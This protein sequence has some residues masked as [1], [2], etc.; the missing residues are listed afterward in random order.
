MV[1][2]EQVVAFRT[3]AAGHIVAIGRMKTVGTTAGTEVE[4]RP[5]VGLDNLAWV[6]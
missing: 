5:A 1:V 6:E 4:V 3:L 2:V